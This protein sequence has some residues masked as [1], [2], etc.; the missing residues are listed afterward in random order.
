VT[1]AFLP[2]LLAALPGWREA[3]AGAVLWAAV[4]SSSAAFWLVS[5]EKFGTSNWQPILIVFALGGLI[6]FPAG[7]WLARLLAPGR[8]PGARFAAAFLSLGAA[9]ALGV[10]FVFSMQYR[11]YYAQWHE[12]FPAIAWFFQL[13]FTGAGA[14]YQFAVLGMRMFFPVAFVALLAFGLWHA[15]RAR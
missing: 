7:L 14:V 3:A 5:V 12:H 9:S 10:A 8:D 13:A 11:T 4:T 15:R 6:A 1:P 2:R